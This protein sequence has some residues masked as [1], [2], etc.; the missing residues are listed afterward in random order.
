MDPVGALRGF[1]RTDDHHPV[2]PGLLGR[3]AVRIKA[4]NHLVSAV[5]Q[6]LRLRMALAPVAEDCDGFALQSIG[7]GVVL[8]ENFGGHWLSPG[9]TLCKQTDRSVGSEYPMIFGL[10]CQR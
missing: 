1:Q 2:L 5:T 8:I 3:A 10:A 7:A 4:D 9:L 6:V